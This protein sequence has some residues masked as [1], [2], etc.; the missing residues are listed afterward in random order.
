MVIHIKYLL[1]LFHIPGISGKISITLKPGCI[2]RPGIREQ[3]NTLFLN[4][5]TGFE[6]PQCYLKFKHDGKYFNN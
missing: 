3:Q 1:K 6:N 5:I 4:N 2:L